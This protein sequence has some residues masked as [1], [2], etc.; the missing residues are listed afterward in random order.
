MWTVYTSIKDITP[1][2]KNWK[3]KMIVAE[4]SPKRISQRTA[5]KY[6]NLILIDKEGNR[7]QATMFGTDIDPRENTLKIL[8]SYYII[9][10]Y[11]KPVDPK[12]KIGEYQYQWTLNSKTIIEDVPQNEEQIDAPKYEIIPF[13]D[14]EAYRGSIGEIGNLI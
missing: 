9:D 7:V 2:T 13:K 8:Q 1:K 14:L 10:A 6:Q 12:Y 11:V 5:V 3:I 4:K